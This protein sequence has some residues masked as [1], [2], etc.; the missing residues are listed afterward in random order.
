VF[1]DARNALVARITDLVLDAQLGRQTAASLTAARAL[2]DT[3]RLG[4]EVILQVGNNGVV[5]KGQFDQFMEVFRGVRRV[6]V[7]NVRVP[8]PWE[9][10]N[11]EV[12]SDGV[13][14]TPNAV[15]VDWNKL[16]SAHPDVFESDSVHLTRAGTQLLVDAIAAKL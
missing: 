5:T 13:E 7:V 3:G 9:E 14:R 11:N 4:D 8:R 1:D 12:L 15:L 10:P 16:G 6:V 2:R